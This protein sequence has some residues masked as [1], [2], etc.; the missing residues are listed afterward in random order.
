VDI[1][2]TNAVAHLTVGAGFSGPV[3]A[4]TSKSTIEIGAGVDPSMVRF[5]GTTK[6]IFDFGG[7]EPSRIRSSRGAIR[8]SKSDNGS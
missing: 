8:V 5:D 3:T 2:T 7:G 6:A 1:V 4:E